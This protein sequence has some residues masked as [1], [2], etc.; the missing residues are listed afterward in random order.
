[1]SGFSAVGS[2]LLA[3]GAAGSEKDNIKLRTLLPCFVF[4]LGG[5]AI[6]YFT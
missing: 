5:K 1:V 4:V 3:L 6:K 2:H